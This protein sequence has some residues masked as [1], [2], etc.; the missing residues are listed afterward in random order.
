MRE[1]LPCRLVFQNNLAISSAK[2]PSTSLSQSR[3]GPPFLGPPSSDA[4]TVKLPPQPRCGNLE[5]KLEH[6]PDF[7]A[8]L[9]WLSRL[10]PLSSFCPELPNGMLPKL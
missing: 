5:L 3:G 6:C 7:P 10:L 1:M 4:T 9:S 8:A 2:T